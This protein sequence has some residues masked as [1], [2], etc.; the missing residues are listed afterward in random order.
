M[1]TPF[2]VV[3]VLILL[4]AGFF[5]FKP[6]STQYVTPTQ[7]TTSSSVIVQPVD[8][9][10]SFIIKTD[11]I[12][13]SFKAEKYHNKSL[14]VYITADD[15]T[16]VH[17]KKV[18]ITWDDFFKTLPM[19]L[20][21]DCLITGDGETFCDRKQG[22]LKFY[23]SPKGREILIEDKDFLDKEINQN[24]SLLVKFTSS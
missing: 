4:I 1:K 19:Q 5:I 16:K 14:D 15:P 22:T 13:R 2:I 20:T 11:S 6:K 10:A 21:K 18:G 9:T 7:S 24:D 17:V 8:I 23:I 3:I 12:I